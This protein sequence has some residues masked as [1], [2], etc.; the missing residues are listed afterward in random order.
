MTGPQDT[1]QHSQCSGG[2]CGGSSFWSPAASLLLSLLF[3]FSL[4]LAGLPAPQQT[5]AAWDG[6]GQSSQ[7]LLGISL[8]CLMV[9]FGLSVTIYAGPH[10][11]QL[12]GGAG[13]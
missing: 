9:G 3:F 4:F 13:L 10:A 11:P 8:L 12:Q 7:G 6:Q 5:Q 2:V 1:G